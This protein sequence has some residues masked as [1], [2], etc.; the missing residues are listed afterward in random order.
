ML[1]RQELKV[2]DII[3]KVRTNETYV[4]I[5]IE[6]NSVLFIWDLWNNIG[7]FLLENLDPLNDNWELVEYPDRVNNE[8]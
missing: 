6:Y 5:S 2:G 3:R 4:I 7:R 1:Y 8:K